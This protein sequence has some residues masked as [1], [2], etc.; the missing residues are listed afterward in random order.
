MEVRK[1]FSGE[2]LCKRSVNGKFTVFISV[3]TQRINVPS[4]TSN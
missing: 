1:I 2:F 4:L 3:V